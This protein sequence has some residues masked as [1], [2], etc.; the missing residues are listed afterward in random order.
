MSLVAFDDVPLDGAFDAGSHVGGIAWA[1]RLDARQVPAGGQI[2]C[3]LQ[4]MH[5]LGLAVMQ[6]G[7]RQAGAVFQQYAVWHHGDDRHHRIDGG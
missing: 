3:A 2:G 6:G 5:Q 7:R 4:H 1:R